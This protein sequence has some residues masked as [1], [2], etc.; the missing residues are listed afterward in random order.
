MRLHSPTAHWWQYPLARP[1]AR[2]QQVN[3]LVRDLAWRYAR[4]TPSEQSLWETAAGDWPWWWYCVPWLFDGVP[5]DT[6]VGTGVDAYQGVNASNYCNGLDVADTPPIYTTLPDADTLALVPVTGVSI[7]WSG[8]V[9]APAGS[10]VAHVR[11]CPLSHAPESGPALQRYRWAG[12]VPISYETPTSIAAVC[13]RVD[14]FGSMPFSS[15][16]VAVTDLG[17]APWFGRR[18]AVE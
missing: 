11:V 16:A 4:L 13:S 2:F 1:S 15:V 8:R 10:F 5:F 18:L 7:Y 17:A 9:S 3:K 6:A 12:A 14:G